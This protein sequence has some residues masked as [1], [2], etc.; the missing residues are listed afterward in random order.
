MAVAMRDITGVSKKEYD[1]LNELRKHVK[2]T[3]D[4]F[5]LTNQNLSFN[6]LTKTATISDNRITS[7]SCADVTFHE[8]SKV[9]DLNIRGNTTTGM[10]EF[11]CDDVPT[12]KWDVLN[13]SFPGYCRYG[14]AVLDSDGNL[15]IIGGSG[16]AN[17]RKHYMKNSSGNWVQLEDTPM[18]G[19]S[20]CTLL[21]PDGYINVIGGSGTNP[22]GTS[23]SLSH[24]RYKDGNW[25]SVSTLPYQFYA[26]CAIVYDGSIHIFGSGT[27]SYRK[28]HYSYKDGVWV[29]EGELPYPMYRS[30]VCVDGDNMIHLLGGIRA[31]DGS[32]LYNLNHYMMSDIGWENV[33]TL[34]ASVYCSFATFDPLGQLHIIGGRYNDQTHWVYKNSKWT[35]L[36]NLPYYFV[37]DPGYVTENGEIVLFLEET[38]S[39]GMNIPYYETIFQY[40]A[41]CN[42]LI[43]N[44]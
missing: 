25:E 14:K 13:N 15:H 35:Q 8:I 38:N 10:V 7:N 2:T 34:P 16:S 9:S 30:C 36:D 5:V 28:N 4:M 31:D 26:G 21:G 1:A 23:A 22:D 37:D 18:N 17:R 32:D 24:Y 12:G 20:G 42:I 39:T 44:P 6:P 3:D 41:K 43:T 40:S 19:N 29:D 33:E 11:L 27:E